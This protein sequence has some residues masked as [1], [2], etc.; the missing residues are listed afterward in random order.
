MRLKI[1]GLLVLLAA[2]N[3]RAHE[4]ND[5]DIYA[6]LGPFIYMTHP[7]K[8]QFKSPQFIGPALVVEA[9]LYKYGGLE[10]GMFYLKNPMSVTQRGMTYTQQV[11]RVYI[12]TGYRHWFHPKLSAAL[13]FASSY[14]MGAPETLQDEFSGD[15]HGGTSASDIT[16]YGVDLSVQYEVWRSGRFAATV[17]GRYGYA[18]TAKSDEDENHMGLLIGLKYFVQS[19]EK[20]LSDG[21]E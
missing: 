3:A 10:I 7:L 16:E 19:R 13:A 17:E 2:V 4:P 18:I 20:S 6:T 11:K 21:G 1:I 15:A 9:D 5:G 8:H 12:A 14:T